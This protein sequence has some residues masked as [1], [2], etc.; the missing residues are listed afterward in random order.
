MLRWLHQ[1]RAGATHQPAPPSDLR[2]ALPRTFAT[3]FRLTMRR[4]LPR[5]R[6]PPAS[7]LLA[8]RPTTPSS[9]LIH[10]RLA[11]SSRRAFSCSSQRHEGGQEAPRSPFRVF[12]ETLKLEI[13]K[14][15]DLQENVKQ[16]QG[17]VGKLQDSES[18]RKAKELYERARITSILREN[19]RLREAAD[20]MK[21]SGVKVSDAVGEALRQVEES[22]FLRA[23]SFL[24]LSSF[25]PSFCSPPDRPSYSGRVR[26][27]LKKS[28]PPLACVPSRA[29]PSPFRAR[30]ARPLQLKKSR[31]A[32]SSAASTATAPVRNTAAYKALA[33]SVS[34]VFDDSAASRYG[35]YVEKEVRRKKRQAR[36]EKLGRNGMGV[37]SRVKANDE[38]G[39][40]LP[41]PLASFYCPLELER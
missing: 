37:G 9:S 3:F 39:P 13:E 2:A 29:E 16:L 27:S 28:P 1:G 22:E 17:D 40:S 25:A 18:M 31:D 33:E 24:P 14:N 8:A 38:L 30:S 19:P 23:V 41:L 12:V 10:L 21:R 36:L 26:A 4:S 15:R 35:G 5:T 7:L 34:E 32:V 11:L 20:E 6:L